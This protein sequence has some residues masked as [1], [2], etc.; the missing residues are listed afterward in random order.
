MIYMEDSVIHHLNN[1]G[2]LDNLLFGIV[3]V[4]VVVVVCLSFLF[5]AREQLVFTGGQNLWSRT[6]LYENVPSLDGQNR[7]AKSSS[8]PLNLVSFRP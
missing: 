7:R 2:L 3:L 4:A 6:S 1:P 8:Q 5:S